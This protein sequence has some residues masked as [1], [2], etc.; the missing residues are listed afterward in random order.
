MFWQ[1]RPQQGFYT[2]LLA[3]GE[4]PGVSLGFG[5]QA[6]AVQERHGPG[7]GGLFGLVV[8]EHRRLDEVAEHA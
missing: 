8:H 2:L 4:I 5:E 7:D 6:H 1:D 3:A